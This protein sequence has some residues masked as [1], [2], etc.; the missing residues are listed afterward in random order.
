MKRAIKA[1]VDWDFFD[2]FQPIVDD[3]LP[4]EGEG[5]TMAMQLAAA[6]SKLVYRYYNDGDVYDN[7]ANLESMTDLSDFA[8]W[9]Y[10]YFPSSRNILK[11]IWKVKTK[12]EYEDILK[13]LCEEL[14]N[15]DTLYEADHKPRRDSI[16]H[17]TTGPFTWLDPYFEED[18]KAWG[19][20]SLYEDDNF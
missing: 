12:S 13:E 5:N 3:Y 16:Y 8:N 19:E 18:W 6:I 14:I 4:D 7:T 15:D 17:Y 9:I 20:E 1:S 10:I 11:R 2:K